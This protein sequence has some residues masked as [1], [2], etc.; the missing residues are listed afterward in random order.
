MFNIEVMRI[1]SDS[2]NL[3][4]VGVVVVK[5]EVGREEEGWLALDV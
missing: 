3:W 2:G 4:A 1:E 5:Q